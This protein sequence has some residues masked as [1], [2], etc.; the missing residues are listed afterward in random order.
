MLIAVTGA[1][2]L[3]GR[4][5]I[6]LLKAAGHR[7]IAATRKPR[8]GLAAQMNAANWMQSID[9]YRL[10]QRAEV[11]VH[12][13]GTLLP[14]HPDSYETCNLLPAERVAQAA[15]HGAVSRVLY[16]SYPGA[17]EGSKNPYLRTK[18]L[19]EKALQDSGKPLLV[20]RSAS[21]IGPPASPGPYGRSLM[22][23]EQGIVR[24]LGT[25]G[26]KV[27]PVLRG[28]VVKALF[29]AVGHGEPGVHTLWGPVTYRLDALIA[30]LNLGAPYRL[31][32]LHPWMARIL[33][34]FINDLPPWPAIDV[35]TKSELGDPSATAQRF[36][37]KL[38]TLES[39]WKVRP[40][41]S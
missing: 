10:L 32:M 36:G 33:G 4:D 17:S 13:A 41:T 27:Q 30:L 25:R 12:L 9:S 28:D 20:L 3:V 15:K 19:A 8:P 37:L 31:Q 18:A 26:L 39:V 6:R 22:A 38:T 23:N 11:I 1:D 34:N 21:I 35:L 24:T 14:V 16:L 2:G 7:V 29:A 40:G 5:L